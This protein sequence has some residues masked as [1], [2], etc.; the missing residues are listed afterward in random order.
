MTDLILATIARQLRRITVCLLLL[1]FCGLAGTSLYAQQETLE[2]RQPLELVFADSI[3]PQDRHELMSTT[4]VWYFRH[5]ALHNA[6]LTQKVEWGL[7]DQLQISVF[8]HLVNSSTQ[9]G[10]RATGI[11]DIEIGARYTWARVGSEFTHIA[12]A[13]D[14]GFPTGN[15][16]RGLSEGNYSVSPSIL[17]SRELQQ[18]KYQLFATTGAEF[19]TAHR[20][21]VTFQDEPRN[22]IFSNGGISVHAG[23]GWIV[24]E[25]SVNSNRVNGGSETQLSLTPSYVRRIAKR[26]EILIG[27]PLGLTSSTDHIGGVVKFTFELGG[28]D[29]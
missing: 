10:P 12:V 19:I 26:T 2:Q 13:L 24:S 1:L 5:D 9:G 3:V 21:L 29:K 25:F 4:G 18:G 20:R 8:A 14:A 28:G 6:S 16:Q 7:S 23:H 27:V 22:S 11:G 17:F 15:S